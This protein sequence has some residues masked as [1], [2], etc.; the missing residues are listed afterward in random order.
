M[1]ETLV[2][3]EVTVYILAYR[4][5]EGEQTPRRA[6]QNAVRRL[7]EA[8]FGPDARLEHHSDGA[9]YVAGSDRFISVSHSRTLAVLAVAPFP[10]GVD[11]EEPRP[12]LQRIAG[13]FLSAEEQQ[14]YRTLPELL[15]AWTLKEAAY[16]ALR[17]VLPATAMP[18]PPAPLPYTILHSA[19]Y[20]GHT[21]TLVRPAAN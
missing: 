2:L 5:A 13:R 20:R 12:Q 9:P 14:H 15:T 1:I 4:R 18:L 8:A 19:P 21:L 16:K 10:V 6:E 11:I 7:V 17:P 3:G